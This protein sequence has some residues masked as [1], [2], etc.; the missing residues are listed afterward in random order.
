MATK[1]EVM[2]LIQGATSADWEEAINTAIA[3]LLGN[4]AQAVDAEVL[5]KTAIAEH[6][7]E[8]DVTLVTEAMSI[9]R[10]LIAREAV[11]GNQED[12]YK[13]YLIVETLAMLAQLHWEE[14]WDVMRK[15]YEDTVAEAS[16]SRKNRKEKEQECS[17]LAES[18][19][20]S[21]ETSEIEGDEDMALSAEDRAALIEATREGVVAG[22]APILEAIS[23]QVAATTALANAISETRASAEV[24]EAVA[25]AAEE[26]T[27]EVVEAVAEVVEDAPTAEAEVETEEVVAEVETE[28]EA[29]AEVDEE[30]ESAVAEAEAEAEVEVT[31]SV[32]SAGVR[33]YRMDT[34]EGRKEYLAYVANP[35]NVNRTP[36][37]GRVPVGKV[38]TAGAET[39]GS[40]GAT[41]TKEEILEATKSLF[42]R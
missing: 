16:M 32:V 6:N 38:A 1:S 15:E 41:L 8:E 42:Q 27:E 37:G 12:I 26:E 40:A 36:E 35:N 22:L 28:T 18:E 25:E 5:D 23:S 2:K 14:E 19:T 4:E 3:S 7:E 10:E 9:L 33:S 11:D 30:L 31:N 17:S 39:K 29:V 24:E 20:A 21:V 34:A 13:L